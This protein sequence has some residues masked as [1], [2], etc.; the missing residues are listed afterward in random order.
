MGGCVCVCLEM[1]KKKHHAVLSQRPVQVALRGA[2]SE[3]PGSSAPAT[4]NRKCDFQD[5]DRRNIPAGL[6]AGLAKCAPEKETTFS[7]PLDAGR[8]A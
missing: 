7:L 4:L 1:N 2:P 6:P 5:D 8:A 3:T